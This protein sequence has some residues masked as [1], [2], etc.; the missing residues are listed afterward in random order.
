LRIQAVAF[1]GAAPFIFGIGQA[2]TLWVLYG[3]LAV[4]GFFRGIY[5]SNIFASLYEIVD[6]KSRAT[7]SGLILMIAFLTGAISPYLLGLLKPILGF[8][9]SLSLLSVFY[10]LAAGFMFLGTLFFDRDKTIL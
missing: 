7:A 4:F 1:L 3:T 2:Q 9:L 10:V 6:A 8:S 5:D